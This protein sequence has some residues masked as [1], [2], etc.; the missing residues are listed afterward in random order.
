MPSSVSIGFNPIS[1][2]NS[3]PSFLEAIKL[4]AGAHRPG[5]GL[6]IKSLAQSG[7]MGPIPRR[8]EHFDGL[9]EEFRPRIAEHPLGLGIDHD[10]G[11]RPVNHDHGAR[12]SLDDQPE[13]PLGGNRLFRLMIPLA[14]HASIARASGIDSLLG[15]VLSVVGVHSPPHRNLRPSPAS[16]KHVRLGSGGAEHARFKPRC[17]ATYGLLHPC[18]AWLTPGE[19]SFVRGKH[20]GSLPPECPRIQSAV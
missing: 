16:T 8:Y 1:T 19:Y 9:T 2:G 10:N 6:S 3:L 5:P 7:M 14:R 20:R 4:A 13:P 18:G 17:P 15:V 12:R 11:A